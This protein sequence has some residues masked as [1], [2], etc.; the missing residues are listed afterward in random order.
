MVEKKRFHKAIAIWLLLL[1]AVIAV[2]EIFPF[3]L[4][5]KLQDLCYDFDRGGWLL[6]RNDKLPRA[7]FYYGM[8]YLVVLIGVL[9]LIATCSP[10]RWLEKIG[11]PKGRER[12]SAA[13]VLFCI[14]TVPAL[15]GSL[16]HTTGIYY[17]SQ[18]DR[19][20]GEVPYVGLF[21]KIPPEVL[22]KRRRGR[23]WP[24]GH[25]SGGFALM[26]LVYLVDRE[27][28][29]KV[30]MATFTYGLLMGAYQ[31]VNG[32]HYVSHTLVTI[33]LAQIIILLAG[34]LFRLDPFVRE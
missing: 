22:T 32:A 17:P 15:V 1:L 29:R 27:K 8:K 25:A 12:R 28:R 7:I 5:L 23:G 3:K 16:K 11:L 19:Y 31:T 30:L 2:F 9:A 26:S 33:C 10:L 4:D 18:V 34:M 20:G 6:D 21:E 13:A 24:A 14:A